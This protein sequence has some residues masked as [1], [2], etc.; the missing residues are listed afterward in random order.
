MWNPHCGYHLR[1][2]L[3]FCALCE[4]LWFLIR[5]CRVLILALLRSR[6]ARGPLGIPPKTS[7]TFFFFNFSF[8]HTC[9]FTE[10]Q[11]H[12]IPSFLNF[13]TEKIQKFRSE[14]Q[15][16]DPVREGIEDIRIGWW[17]FLNLWP[18]LNN[19]F[20]FLPEKI[21]N[22]IF[23]VPSQ[24]TCRGFFDTWSDLDLM[25]YT[26]LTATLPRWAFAFSGESLETF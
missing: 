22:H 15:V 13:K 5:L 16:D 1:F 21:F 12:K 26:E 3:V 17:F 4:L 14:G 23:L 20:L 11:V 6:H 2:A 25:S 9:I 8:Q 7:K 24:P 18:K 10:L 19:I